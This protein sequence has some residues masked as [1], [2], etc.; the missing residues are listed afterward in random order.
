MQLRS[1]ISLESCQC[2]VSEVLPSSYGVAIAEIKKLR[3]STSVHQVFWL[4][5]R[6][7]KTRQLPRE[8]PG[9][10][11]GTADPG[12]PGEGGGYHITW[13]EQC[14]NWSN[15]TLGSSGRIFCSFVQLI[16]RL[17]SDDLYSMLQYYPQPGQRSTGLAVQSSMLYV[18][19]YFVP[20]ILR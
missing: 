11:P 5:A 19:L 4:P 9:P 17:R 7:Q 2:A 10:G 14:S 8:P 16:G 20:Q 1:N 3:L 6:Q 13:L 18:L 12:L 15:Q